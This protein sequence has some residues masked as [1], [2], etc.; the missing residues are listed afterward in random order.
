LFA[1]DGYSLWLVMAHLEAGTR[2][3]WSA[4]HGD[5]GVYV[6]S[7]AVTVSNA[8]CEAGGAVIVESG[9]PAEM[10]AEETTEL[11]HVGP[12][13]AGSSSS[14]GFG[15]ANPHDVHVLSGDTLDPIAV[16]SILHHYYADSTCS[17]CQIAFFRIDSSGDYTSPSHVHSEDEIIHVLSGSL[18]FGRQTVGPGM[19]IA[20]PA[21]RRYG[22]RSTEPF[23]FLNYRADASTV[24]MAPG[25]R[26]FEESASAVRKLAQRQAD[27]QP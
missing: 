17:T 27:H 22:F 14:N 3:Q 6:S 15:S 19:S 7:G 11:V 8:T 25:T 20:I 16:G 12:T 4:V 18:Q 9:F 13:L 23:S 1:P 21:E 2:V 10:H 26:A 24:T 5:E